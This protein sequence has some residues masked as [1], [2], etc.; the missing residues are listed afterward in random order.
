MSGYAA[1]TQPDTSM[2][3]P[4]KTL[5][6]LNGLERLGIKK[7]LGRMTALAKEL[8]SPH[9][10]FPSV[11]VAGT[12]GKGST[13]AM[14]AS[15]LAEAG[16]KAGLYTSPHLIKLNERIR[17]DGRP[18]SGA[19]LSTAV[20]A[21]KKAA[22]KTSTFA[23]HPTF[24]EFTTATAFVHFAARKT[25]IA[26]IEAGMGGRWDAT[27]II[28]PLVS[29][30]TNVE[31]D[32]TEVLG[33]TIGKIAFEKAGI[34]KKGA[35]VVT[36][37]KKP[38]ALAP[39]MKAAKEK[40]S[41]VYR[42]GNE[43]DVR[44]RKHGL[45]DYRGISSGLIGLETRLPG[46]HQVKN[47]AC[48]LAAI[49]LLKQK[50]WKIPEAAIRRG[51][52]KVSWPARVEVLRKRPL[53]IIDSAHNPAGA[54]ALKAALQGFK[55]KKLTLVL[56]ILGDKDV[57]GIVNE[58]APLA[59]TLILTTPR[60]IRGAP[61]GDLLRLTNAKP[62]RLMLITPVAQACEAAL[63]AAEKEDAVCVAGSVYTAGEAKAFFAKTPRNAL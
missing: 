44:A 51:L 11:H 42:L 35:P 58:L 23:A 14:L 30:I 38:D 39:I 20:A 37:E 36:A 61:S 12:N 32:H 8:D 2:P 54:S 15:I 29:I 17:L 9:L 26:V 33:A 45:F 41:P 7:G 50:G 55:F 25:D 48:A 28:R 4:K 43:F 63:E 24:F 59:H 57:L 47:A 1:L 60:N 52:K 34:I 62:E 19:D 31:L 53:V 46:P 5:E 6:Y 27:N 56:G 40:G 49:E 22:P 21:V 3:S 18:I 10:S 16:Y 13:S